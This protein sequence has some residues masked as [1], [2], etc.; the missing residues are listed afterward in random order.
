MAQASFL[1]VLCQDTVWVLAFFRMLNRKYGWG[2]TVPQKDA[3][4]LPGENG[5]LVFFFN[6]DTIP[7]EEVAKIIGTT[8]DVLAKSKD[9]T[10]RE[11]PFSCEMPKPTGY[12]GTA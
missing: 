8:P 5:T 12:W 10:L 7:M 6:R 4:M 3:Y 2:N 9:I 11:V 1:K